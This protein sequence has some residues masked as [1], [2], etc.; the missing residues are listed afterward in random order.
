MPWSKLET[1]GMTK[2]N[3]LCNCG[4][5]NI[6]TTQKAGEKFKPNEIPQYVNSYNNT[7]QTILEQNDFLITYI[8][9]HLPC[10]LIIM[11]KVYD[12]M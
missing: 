6:V 2:N 12:I 5:A 7:V 3:W 9:L 1:L 8:L 11:M 4:L 10:G